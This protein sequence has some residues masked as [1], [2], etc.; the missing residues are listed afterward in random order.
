MTKKRKA[1]RNHV[2][3]FRHCVRST[4]DVTSS[5]GTNRSTDPS[6]YISAELP[7]WGVPQMFCT[8]R[9]LRIMQS[10]GQFLAKLLIKE[11]EMSSDDDDER[12]NRPGR[13]IRVR[14]VSD[15][16][17]RDAD[18]AFSMI[19]G[20]LDVGGA[21][22]FDIDLRYDEQLF[23]PLMARKI[24]SGLRGTNN[25]Y[26]ETKYFCEKRYTSEILR[27]E[28]EERLAT[29]PRPFGEIADNLKFLQRITGVGRAGPFASMNPNEIKIDDN[30]NIVG[31]VNVLALFSQMLFYARVSRTSPTFVPNA[32]VASIYHM[33]QWADWLQA[34]QYM[35]NSRALTDV[36]PFAHSIIEA[37]RAN[38]MHEESKVTATIFVG[39][40]SDIARLA[41]V[42]GVRWDLSKPYHTNR[43]HSSAGK[44][45]PAPP[46]STM[47]FVHDVPSGKVELAFR[48]PFLLLDSGKVFWKPDLQ[49][50]PMN[51]L[52][53]SSGKRGDE[54]TSN[55]EEMGRIGHSIIEPYPGTGG[56]GIDRL[57]NRVLAIL[58]QY[59]GA[60]ECYDRAAL[61]TSWPENVMNSET[62][63]VDTFVGLGEQIQMLFSME[64]LVGGSIL[65]LLILLLGKKCLNVEMSCRKQELNCTR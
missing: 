56:G 64:K 31:M 37:L 32:T 53:L 34:V 26:N 35:D 45:A 58:S 55:E 40:D 1:R 30:G 8:S 13:K 11:N 36:A 7:E 27:S 4:E 14:F 25:A 49:S 22:L 65:L 63:H 10:T 62:S 57:E 20:F 3:V 9:G 50:T 51:L 47:Q 28:V 33:L 43:N 19:R 16:V 39:H 29:L 52:P 6:D 60:S 12:N 48:Y 42:F 2:F 54:K 59:D 17:I 23:N 38:H 21:E 61:L 46:G 41:S 5:V 15:V 44:Y 24:Q 18:T